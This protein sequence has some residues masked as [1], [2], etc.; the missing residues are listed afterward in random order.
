MLTRFLLFT[1]GLTLLLFVYSCDK[2]KVKEF[3]GDFQPETAVVEISLAPPLS[4]RWS[5]ISGLDWHGDKLVFLPQ[6]PDRFESDSDGLLFYIGKEQIET[7]LDDKNSSA[8]VPEKINLNCLWLNDQIDGFQGFEA[9]AFRDSVAYLAIEA[10]NDTMSGYLVMGIVNENL[11]SIGLNENKIISIPMPV[12]IRNTAFETLM[13]TDRFVIAVYEANGKNV[14]PTALAVYFDFQLNYVGDLPFPAIEYRVT[15]AT[16]INNDSTFWV[17]NYF[18]NKEMDR[19]NPADDVL[20]QKYGKGETHYRFTFSERLINLKL[21][22]DGIEYGPLP[23]LQIELVS[24]ADQRNWE[25]LVILP[26]RGFLI[27]TDKFPRTIFGFIPYA[28]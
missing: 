11:K 19:Y 5:E 18:F 26:G 6:Y 12:Q 10:N 14:N 2:E 25:G 4:E 24:D 20:E 9:I 1:A 23:P 15:D 16:R 28:L 22:P 27:V 7:Y 13:I 21:G 8:I 17:S 3:K